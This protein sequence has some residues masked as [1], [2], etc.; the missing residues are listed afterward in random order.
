MRGRHTAIQLG[1]GEDDHEDVGTG[2]LL[3][4]VVAD[5]DAHGADDKDGQQL[6]ADD[7]LAYPSVFVWAE[8]PDRAIAE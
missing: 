8:P 4:N 6:Q 3:C 2:V 7:A 5:P 1:R